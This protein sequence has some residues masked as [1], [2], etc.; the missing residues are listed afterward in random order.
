MIRLA[1]ALACWCLWTTTAS[2]E[3]ILSLD[4]CADQYVL[5]LAPDADLMLTPRSDDDDSFFRR[6]ASG[7]P[8]ARVSLERALMFRP[9]VVVRTWGGDPRL[10]AALRNDGARIIDIPDVTDL[11]GARA[12]LI[13][14]GRALGRQE[15]AAREAAR[16]DRRLADVRPRAARPEALYLTAGGYTAGPGAFVD[17]LLQAGGLANATRQPGFRPVSLERLVLTPPAMLV[18]GFFDRR[19]SDWR[20]VGRHP[21]VT[22]LAQDRPVARPAA[23]TLSCPAWFA[24]ETLPELSAAR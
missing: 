19:R 5:A 6:A 16:L 2:A 15:A 11:S 12:N 14:V 17:S 20:G 13:D 1:L 3:R 4:S 23:A 7:H 22:R 10:I 8:R 24:A 21:L 9:D 18:L